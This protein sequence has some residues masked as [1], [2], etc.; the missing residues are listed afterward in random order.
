M[1]WRSEVE[2]RPQRQYDFF[3]VLEAFS[4]L[5]SDGKWL[6]GQPTNDEHPPAHKNPEKNTMEQKNTIVD[7]IYEEFAAFGKTMEELYLLKQV[8]LDLRHY[9][10]MIKL[11]RYD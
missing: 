7:K 10:R 6:S 8:S 4:F 1:C 5:L 11:K 3:S 9:R 2:G